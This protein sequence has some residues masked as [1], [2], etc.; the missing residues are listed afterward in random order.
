MKC[1]S[2]CRS[3]LWPV[4]C[5][6]HT[7]QIALNNLVC[8]TAVPA[9]FILIQTPIPLWFLK[10][11][12]S[13]NH[14]VLKLISRFSLFLLK[15]CIAQCMSLFIKWSWCTL[16]TAV[17]VCQVFGN[18][19]AELMSVFFIWDV[20]APWDDSLSASRVSR[21]LLRKDCSRAANTNI[22]YFFHLCSR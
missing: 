20:S 14:S 16:N 3:A 8:Y 17:T 11:P 4:P 19:C 6:E 1:R 12:F 21:P 10:V 13:S 22:C 5:T 2:L 7:W 18:D 15:Y 9:R